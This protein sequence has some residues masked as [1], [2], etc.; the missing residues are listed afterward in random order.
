MILKRLKPVFQNIKVKIDNTKVNAKRIKN[1]LPQENKTELMIHE[2][3]LV[4]DNFKA[5]FREQRKIKQ[6]IDKI[7][8]LKGEKVFDEV[9]QSFVREI[10]ENM[11]KYQK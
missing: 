11:K 5:M 8:N 7:E 2:F 10:C 4:R 6:K 3:E 1:I 9:H